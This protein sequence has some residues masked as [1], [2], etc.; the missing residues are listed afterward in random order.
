M[1]KQ[2]I[3]PH[4]GKVCSCYRNPAPTVDVVI[5]APDKGIVIIERRNEPYGYALP[6]GFIDY[7]EQAERAAIREMKEETSLDVRL[8]GLLG[9][10]SNPQRD[11]RR[12]TISTVFVGEAMA[13]D[14]L[15]AGDDAREARFYHL[16]NLPRP[17]VFDHSRIIA[18][19]R[20]YL[21]GERCLAP[22]EPLEKPV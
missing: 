21:A 22:I 5:Y 14:L 11:P 15:A 3:C 17:L 18:D 4:C 7:G 20:A 9:V 2:I 19:F 10:Y 12:H 13:P 6:G 1:E 16:D 8:V